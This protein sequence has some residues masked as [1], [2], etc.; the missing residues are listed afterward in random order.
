VNSSIQN[1]IDIHRV[2]VEIKKFS[3]HTTSPLYTDFMQTVQ[4]M[5]KINLT[6][7]FTI[8]RILKACHLAILLQVLAREIV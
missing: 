7:G 6:S 2:V 8:N 1:F 5:H 3:T 4:R